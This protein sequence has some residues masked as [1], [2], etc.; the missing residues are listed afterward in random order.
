MHII[1][2]PHGC[3]Q[4][5]LASARIHP[6]TLCIVLDLDRDVWRYG[7]QAQVADLQ[8]H[9]AHGRSAVEDMAPRAIHQ[10]PLRAAQP[11][12]AL[13]EFGRFGVEHLL[14]LIERKWQE[15][16]VKI[17]TWEFPRILFGVGWKIFE[18]ENE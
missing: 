11:S 15:V 16:E 18:P 2:A 8:Q 12:S 17:L 3:H 13:L 1:D 9:V 6:G 4:N 7:A 5:C 10:L 14:Q